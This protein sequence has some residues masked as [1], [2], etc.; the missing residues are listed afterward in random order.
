[1]TVDAPSICVIAL[2]VAVLD[3]QFIPQEVSRLRRSMR[4]QRFLVRQFELELVLQEG[5]E[6]LFDFLCFFL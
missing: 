2:V 4:N 6:L 5:L 3:Y 1:M